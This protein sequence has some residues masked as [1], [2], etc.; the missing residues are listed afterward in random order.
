[1]KPNLQKFINILEKHLKP[2]AD[3]E[4]STDQCSTIAAWVHV[5]ARL[6]GFSSQLVGVSVH[7]E[8]GKELGGHNVGVIEGYFVDFTLSQFHP[9]EKFP[10][11][12]P[13]N[14]TPY[15]Q[16]R[17]DASK[18]YSLDD[19]MS[20]DDGYIKLRAVL[21]EMG[22]EKAKKSTLEELKITYSEG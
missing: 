12:T 22:V 8:S 6:S 7:D 9:N 1:M 16:N 2:Y 17:W 13:K 10:Y 11:I 19:A 21:K 15:Y 5:A 3:K 18:D 4:N 14:K 20:F